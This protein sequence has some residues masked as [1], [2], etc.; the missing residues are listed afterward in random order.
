MSRALAEKVVP[1][2]RIEKSELPSNDKRASLLAARRSAEH[3]QSPQC[4]GIAA[5]DSELL[6]DVAEVLLHGQVT[7]SKDGLAQP[8]G[9]NGS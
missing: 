5:F 3:L 2:H 4:G 9:S 8:I 6:E 7:H 1:V